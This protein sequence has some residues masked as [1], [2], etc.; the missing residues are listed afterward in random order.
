VHR[1]I[2][3][4]AL[5]V[6]LLS[7]ALGAF[8]VMDYGHAGALYFVV[9]GNPFFASAALGAVLVYLGTRPRVR[10]LAGAFGLGLAFEVLLRVWR[11]DVALHGSPPRLLSHAP[12]E[13]AQSIGSGLGAAA[14]VFVLVR[15]VLSKREARARAIDTACAMVIIPAFVLLSSFF[16]HFTILL[17][18]AVLDSLAFAAERG[19][20]LDTGFRLA[21]F[22]RANNNFAWLL[23]I[24]YVELPLAIAF[25]Y[26][27]EKAR[28]TSMRARY[29]DVL[30][31]FVCVGFF[32]FLCYNLCPVI[33][34]RFYFEDWPATPNVDA[35]KLEAAYGAANEL[36]NCIPSLHTSWALMLFWHARP[37]NRGVR[38]FGA[39]FLSLTL[40]ATVGLGWHYIIDLVI[41]FPFSLAIRAGFRS[42]LSWKHAHKHEAFLFGVGITL[43]WVLMIRARADFLFRTPGFSLVLGAIAVFGSLWFEERLTDS[44]EAIVAEASA[45]PSPS[46][47][48]EA[49]TPGKGQSVWPLLFAFTFSGFAGLVY[50]V[51]F[52]KELALTFGSTSK[53][54]TT[55]LAT[56]MGGLAL[57]SYLGAKLAQRMH[58]GRTLSP[59]ALYGVCEAGVAL[60]CAVSPWMFKLTRVLY[61]A[62]AAGTDTSSSW[63]TV[64]QLGLGALA[65]LPPT[66]LMGMTM[67]ALAV[68]LDALSEVEGRS[69]SLGRSVG[70]LYGANTLGAAFGALLAGYVLMPMFHVRGTTWIA[71]ALN[72][73]AAGIAL[74]LAK[75]AR[76]KKTPVRAETT[77][78]EHAAGI[79]ADPK[80]LQ[81]A[82]IILG[83]GGVV[84]LALE[85]TYIHLLAI[86]VGNSVYA[87]SLMLFAF[88]L[89]LGGGSALGRAYLRQGGPLRQGLMLAQGLVALAVVLGCFAWNF[90]PV[91][92]A[93]FY[94]F[95]YT[96]RFAVREFIRF[97][98]CA[99][100]MVPVALAIGAA[101]PLTMEA[102]AVA[103]PNARMLWMGRGMAINTAGNI[104]GALL[105]TFVLLP[106]LEAVLTL[107][108]LAG[109]SL[110]LAALAAQ[111]EYRRMAPIAVP[112]VLLVLVPPL[113]LTMLS[114]GANVY[115]HMQPWGIVFDHA[116]SADGGLTAVSKSLRGERS[117]K[118]LLTNGKFQGDDDP[119]GEMRAQLGFAVVPLVHT[120]HRGNALVIGLGTGVSARTVKNAGF[121]HIEVAE[122]SRDIVTLASKHFAP[123]NEQ[124]LEAPNVKTLITDGRN[125]LMLSKTPYDL[126]SIEL[127]SIWFA[128]AAALYNRE[129]YELVQARLSPEGV[130]QQWIQMHRISH[131][132]IAYVLGSVRSVFPKAW[133][134]FVGNQGIILACRHDCS[135][136][137]SAIQTIDHTKSLAS[138]LRFFEGKAANILPLRVLDTAS[139]D[140]FLRDPEASMLAEQE[141]PVSTDDNLVLEYSTPKGNVR[142]YTESLEDN[143]E[144]L[145]KFTPASVLTG[146]HIVPNEIRFETPEDSKPLQ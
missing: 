119:D 125:H 82:L 73:A 14:L 68:H 5:L 106:L 92:F 91:Y 103:A 33:G 136:R 124:V 126:V 122:L 34:P 120:E 90:I 30:T 11:S 130:L 104:L 4:F 51:V 102:L 94:Q 36:R 86:V 108:V 131:R 109:V 12:I 28:A 137:A 49:P 32:G 83:V 117:V 19:F 46:S 140:A 53:A 9:P 115:F 84:T 47:P 31:S 99:G 66:L 62:I 70:L 22:V 142:P 27:A 48:S 7:E 98:V 23:I 60:L 15:I 65:L 39:A 55:V 85:T 54:S 128:G 138:A 40:M 114:T 24:I 3:R 145:R 41:A 116:V 58:K 63:L 42:Q 79:I 72:F 134:Y 78:S 45:L 135:P 57:G 89:G 133:L 118:T 144:T 8:G 35:L 26:A 18:P 67:P 100:V 112:A 43:F 80:L 21:R 52:A 143:I 127:S 87:F 10:E 2:L 17:H 16:L 37:L 139:I 38:W 13:V 64:L 74:L 69:S 56:Y 6:F 77:A 97:L 95:S 93:S 61:V 59:L 88:L 96:E 121:E 123:I 71:T 44:A 111:F 132:D 107:Q 146:T 50:E 105:G 20:G 101:Y 25:V 110:G 29:D 1:A 75:F 81:T 113:D 129:F 141:Q 76:L